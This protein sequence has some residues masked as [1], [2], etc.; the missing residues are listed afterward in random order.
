MMLPAAPA[1]HRLDRVSSTQDV[2]HGLAADG[3]PTGTV[4]VAAEQTEGRG[5]R[6]RVWHSPRGGLWL[7]VLCRPTSPASAGILSLRA[8]LAIA[9][10]LERIPGLA[11]LW[12]KWPND[13]MLGERKVGGVLGEARW[14]GDTLGWVALGVGLNVSNDPPHAVRLKS[15]AL[16]ERLPQLTPGELV[17]PVA[18]ALRAI[19]APASQLTRAELAAFHARDWLR[20]RRLATPRNAVAAGIAADGALRVRRPDGTFGLVR[21]GSVE[22]APA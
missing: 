14:Q 16:C 10:A 9:T 3:A 18:R 1:V 7:S 19:D 2:L 5:S 20:D 21:S 13:L 6:G 11:P 12:L 8:G 4:V 15:A 22:L 17:E